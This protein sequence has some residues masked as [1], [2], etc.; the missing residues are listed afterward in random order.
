MTKSKNHMSVTDEYQM[1][2]DKFQDYKR[3]G[4][5][6]LRFS[7]TNPETSEKLREHGFTVTAVSGNNKLEYDIVCPIK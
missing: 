4:H 1:I 5:L 2:L 6:Q 3:H 7:L